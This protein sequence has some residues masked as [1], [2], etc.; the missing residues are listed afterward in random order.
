MRHAAHHELSRRI[1]EAVHV[2]EEISGRPFELQH[3]P[4]NALV[5]QRDA[6]TDSLQQAF[7]ALM[8]A[9]AKGD[10]IPMSETLA[11]FPVRLT[12]VRDYAQR[13]LA[14]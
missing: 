5:A 4:E 6:A 10:A 3:V 12:S 1:I 13:V 11:R 2:F 14:S 8:L 7:A 9:L